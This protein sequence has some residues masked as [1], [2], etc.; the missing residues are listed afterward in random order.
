MSLSFTEYD[1]DNESMEIVHGR[2]DPRGPVAILPGGF[3]PPTIAHLGLAEAALSRV[4]TVVF[5]LPRCFPHKEYQDVSRAARLRILTQLVSTN[6]RFA[7]A[8]AGGGLFVEMA[9]E[10]RALYPEVPEVFILCGRDAAQRFTEWP[11]DPALPL[12][13]QWN[14]FSLLVA[15]RDGEYEPRPNLRSH[16]ERLSVETPWDGVSSTRVRDAIWRGQEWKPLVPPDIHALV[17]EAY[18]ASCSVSGKE[19]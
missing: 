12:D 17:A 4:Q 2:I 3:H 1:R 8:F 14:D 15:G 10:L 16:V 7:V 18:S 19:P 13:C 9:R 11:Y 6:P 5:T